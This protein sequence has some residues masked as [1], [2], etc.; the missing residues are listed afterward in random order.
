MHIT[1]IGWLALFLL[2]NVWALVAWSMRDV[3]SLIRDIRYNLKVER[4][5]QKHSTEMNFH[6]HTHTH[7]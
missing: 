6:T 7:K 3:W 4:E 1:L 5:F 2:L